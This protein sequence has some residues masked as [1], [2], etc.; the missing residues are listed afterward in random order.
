MEHKY[1][2]KSTQTC[3]MTGVAMEESGESSDPAANEERAEQETD[4]V[5]SD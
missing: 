1:E 3:S 5:T 4:N 2:L